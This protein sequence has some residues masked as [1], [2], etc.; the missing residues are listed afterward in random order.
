LI[1][2]AQ[3]APLSSSLT[4]FITNLYP[5]LMRCACMTQASEFMKDVGAGQIDRTYWEQAA[6]AE[7]QFAQTESDRTMRASEVGMVLI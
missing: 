1:Y 6:L 5:R 7:I 2:Y 4:N 3:P